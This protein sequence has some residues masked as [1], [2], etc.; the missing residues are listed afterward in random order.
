MPSCAFKKCNNNSRNINK[1]RGVT[2]HSFPPEPGILAK[3][4]RIIRDDLK[5]EDW[6]PKKH[7]RICSAHFSEDKFYLTPA[8]LRKICKYAIPSFRAPKRLDRFQ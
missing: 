7:S 4:V 6:L 2:F 3:W 8:G 1:A 5:D